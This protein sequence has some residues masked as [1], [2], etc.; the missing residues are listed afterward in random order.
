MYSLRGLTPFGNTLNTHVERTLEDS[1]FLKHLDRLS[2]RLLTENS[3]TQ[4]TDLHVMKALQAIVASPNQPVMAGLLF[5]VCSLSAS[6]FNGHLVKDG[7]VSLEIEA[8]APPEVPGQAVNV[9]VKVTNE[10]GGAQSGH[11]RLHGLVDAWF[12]V[13]PVT[14]P[15]RVEPGS[16]GQTTFRVAVS[17]EVY[18]AL[19][20]VHVTARFRSDGTEPR[21]LHAVRVFESAFASERDAAA[22]PG[23]SILHPATMLRLEDEPCRMVCHYFGEPERVLPA[24]TDERTGAVCQVGRQTRGD[25]ARNVLS[26]HPA[27]SGKAGTVHAEFR[28]SLTDQGPVA[29]TF[30]NAIRD[31]VKPEPASDGVTFKVWVDGRV[32]FEHHSSSKTWEEHEVDLS[33]W[34]GKTIRLRLESHPGPDNDTTCDGAYWGDPTLWAGERLRAPSDADWQQRMGEAEELLLGITEGEGV[35]PLQENGSVVWIPGED[36]PQ[37]SVLGFILHG[38]RVLFKGLDISVEG[39]RLGD[40]RSGLSIEQTSVSYAP[41]GLSMRYRLRRAGDVFPL[42]LNARVEQGAWRLAV[43]CPRTVTDIS[44]GPADRKVERAYFG[45][46]YVVEAP[47]PFSLGFGGHGFSAS[48]VG[49]DYAGGLSLLT[50]SDHPPHRLV[51]D[52]AQ[53][54]YSLHTRYNATLTLVPGDRGALDCAI[55]YRPLYDKEAAPGVQA[56]AGR[57]V[58]DYWGGTYAHNLALMRDAV[59]YGL[60]DTLLALHVWQRWGY[61][62]RLPDIF[63][64]DPSMGSLEDLQALS[65]FC[66]AQD[67][68]WGLHDNYIDFYPDAEGYT[69]DWICFTP[70]GQPVKAWLNEGRNARSYRWRPDR[71]LPLVRRNMALIAPALRPSHSFVDVFTSLGPVEFHDREGRFHSALETRARWGEAFAEIRKKLEGP[72]ITTSEAGHD[73][74]TGW[75]DGADCQFLQL[76]P[77]AKRFHVQVPG[78]NWGR[79]PWYDAVLHDRFILHGVGYSGRYQGERP[80]FNYGI[81]S[82]DYLSS[83]ILT[84]HALMTD[85]RAGL[86]GAVRKYWLAQPWARAVA[87][88]HLDAVDFVDGDIHRLRIHWASGAEALVNRSRRDWHVDGS[89]LPPFGYRARAGNVS[90]TVERHGTHIV[91]H[92]SWPDGFYLNARTHDPNAPRAITPTAPELVASGGRAFT[93]PLHWRAASP[94]PDEARVFVHVLGPKAG[95]ASDLHIVAQGDHDPDTPTTAWEGHVRTGTG[96]V[97]RL[98]QGLPPGGYPVVVGLHSPGQGRWELQGDDR[99]HRAYLV[100]TVHV[101]EGEAGPG[102]LTYRPHP[103]VPPPHPLNPPGTMVGI[104]AASTDGAFRLTRTG[105]ALVITPLPAAPP[106][107]I[108]IFVREALQGKLPTGLRVLDPQ[109]QDLG[110]HPF[111]SQDPGVIGFTTRAGDFAYRLSTA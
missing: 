15:L 78:R 107:R 97:I 48:H 60:T 66:R 35:W 72:A 42:H 29:L 108:R 20:P 105:E 75:L 90:S 69:Y 6:A 4:E 101:S 51:M 28:L 22:S 24:G 5:L 44:L 87:M 46:G 38:K 109:G 81:E 80:R 82:D 16:S 92:A 74:L 89:V 64:P 79:V 55:R 57:F 14:Q 10:G 96:T 8:F 59:R 61:D 94:L 85:R 31:H 99:G 65:A 2:I 27:W 12:P 104:G 33:P 84:G 25:V 102:A 58:F 56:K 53:N 73:Q 88:D 32:A 50:A 52:P 13:G 17:N 98:P 45:H 106:A 9:P 68:P 26:M 49:A 47:G 7:P 95:G 54:R 3:S 39:G 71:I 103:Y 37:A 91:E 63:P 41:E 19:Y 86:P 40:P 18:Q 83:E 76:A 1:P 100:G 23:V 36:G 77:E 67:I 34:A 11:V 43:E 62:Y 70:R 110:E 30:A 111:T 93:L 21:D